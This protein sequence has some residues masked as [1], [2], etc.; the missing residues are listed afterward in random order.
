MKPFHPKVAFPREGSLNFPS[1]EGL[2][3]GDSWEGLEVGDSWEG[4][5]VGNS[6]EGLGVES[7]IEYVYV[8]TI[9]IDVPSRCCQK[10]ICYH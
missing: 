1:W 9:A 4:L 5:E 8:L 2:G 6:W 7:R 3:V 10:T